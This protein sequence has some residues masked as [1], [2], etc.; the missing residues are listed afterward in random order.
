MNG[1]KAI[2]ALL[3]ENNA[4][5]LTRVSML[6]GRRGY[7]IDSLTVSETNDPAISR[8]TITAQG[9]DRIIEQIILQTKK[10]VEV[11]AVRLEDE[12]EAILR[13]LLLV[14]LEADE[15]MRAAIREICDVYKAGIVDFSA[16]SIVCEL[17]GKPSKINGFLDVI[18]KYRILE[19]C[20]TGVTAID[21]G[22]KIMLCE[23]KES[24]KS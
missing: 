21:R 17:T 4:N 3:V 7:N 19:L 5:V 10:L 13:E 6:F 8:I 11:K 22:G 2:V 16:E 9:D 15:A 20:R 1:K 23:N 12:N 14:K 18:G 24:H